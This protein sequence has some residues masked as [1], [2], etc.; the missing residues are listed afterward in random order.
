MIHANCKSS[1]QAMLGG[2]TEEKP[3]TSGI[4]HCSL[5]HQD[6]AAVFLSGRNIEVP[7]TGHFIHFELPFGDAA[8][9]HSNNS[10]GILVMQALLLLT[11]PDFLRSEG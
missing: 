5:V 10:S 7:A 2:D 11:Y 3:A 6:V 1:R 4:L 9:R 8:F